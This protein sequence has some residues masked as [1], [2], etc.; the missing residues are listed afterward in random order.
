MTD[1]PVRAGSCSRK[2]WDANHG[3]SRRLDTGGRIISR[4][5]KTKT[6]EISLRRLCMSRKSVQRFCDND[7]HQNK[8]LKRVA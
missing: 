1:P 6:A 4:A 2:I 8:N 7:M 3:P 5:R